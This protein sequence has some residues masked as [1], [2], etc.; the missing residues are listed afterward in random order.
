[1]V[2]HRE[3]TPQWTNVRR[4]NPFYGM[5]SG[6]NTPLW[7]DV[8]EETPNGLTSLASKGNPIIWDSKKEFRFTNI[9]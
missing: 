8:E 3:G 9:S 7:D 2:W 1:M 6:Q 4:G 5:T